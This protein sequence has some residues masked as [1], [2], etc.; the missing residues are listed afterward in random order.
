[1]RHKGRPPM[2]GLTDSESGPTLCASGSLAFV[3]TQALRGHWHPRRMC[4]FQRARGITARAGHDK[5]ARR[6]GS[7]SAAGP[8]RL[9]APRLSSSLGSAGRRCQ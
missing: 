9:T 8:R 3:R 1:M 2:K 6:T 7:L 4:C 5:H